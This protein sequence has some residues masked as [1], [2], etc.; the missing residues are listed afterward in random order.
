VSGHKRIIIK[1][2]QRADI[3]AG[4]LARVVIMLARRWWNE[5]NTTPDEATAPSPDAARA[6]HDDARGNRAAR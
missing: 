2:Q 6:V 1:G 3:D 5:R 4:A